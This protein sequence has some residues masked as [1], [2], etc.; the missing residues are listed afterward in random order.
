MTPLDRLKSLDYRKQRAFLALF[1]GA[2]T[3]WQTRSDTDAMP[4]TG[5]SECEWIKPWRAFWQDE[6]PALGLV[7]FTESAP[8]P[9]PGAIYDSGTTITIGVTDDGRAAREA[10]WADWR[11]KVDAQSDDE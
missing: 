11:A 3:D 2:R 1:A 5:K 4:F 8:F 10:W 7:T 6:L 9:T